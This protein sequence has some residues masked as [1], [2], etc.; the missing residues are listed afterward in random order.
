MR[1][2]LAKNDWGKWKER[3]ERATEKQSKRKG[4]KLEKE[5]R[6]AAC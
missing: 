4:G 3:G 6:E 1:P 5:E 2:R